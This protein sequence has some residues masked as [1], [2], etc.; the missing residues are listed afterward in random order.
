EFGSSL[1]FLGS[2][3]E[4]ELPGEHSAMGTDGLPRRVRRL[5][6]DLRS[7]SASPSALRGDP[8]STSKEVLRFSELS[9]YPKRMREE[10][11][12]DGAHKIGETASRTRQAQRAAPQPCKNTF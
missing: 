8:A 4:G 7:R 1:Y 2:R 9:P 10:N 6:H 3:R 11:K 5:G 12:I